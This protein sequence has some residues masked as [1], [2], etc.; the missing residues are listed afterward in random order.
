MN[1]AD[2]SGQARK[3]GRFV[4]ESLVGNG[5]DGS[6]IEVRDS[7]VAT[8]S[9]GLRKRAFPLLLMRAISLIVNMGEQWRISL[10]LLCASVMH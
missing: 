7:H 5:D 9:G 10:H 4:E 2:F 6:L 1:L 3:P 8:E